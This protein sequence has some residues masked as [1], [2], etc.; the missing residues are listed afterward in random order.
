MTTIYLVRHG[1]V[2]YKV[3]NAIYGREN[4]EL[5]REGLKQ[6]EELRRRFQN[7]EVDICFCSPLIRTVQTAFTMIG[8]R[9]L[10]IKDDRLL[11]REMGEFVGK[12]YQEYDSNKYWDYEANDSSNGVE[13]IHH[14]YNRC[15]DFLKEIL[16][17]YEGKKILVVSHE[18]VLRCMWG[19][20]KNKNKN[21][22]KEKKISVGYFEEFHI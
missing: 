17:K 20:L 9:C 4:V 1:H 2:S 8:D 3:D 10:L 21:N 15:E 12:S 13:D 19:I 5:D 6:S 11:E 22:L 16:R 14:L 7:Y 18:A